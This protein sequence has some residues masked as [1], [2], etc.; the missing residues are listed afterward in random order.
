MPKN[1][2]SDLKLGV[3]IW[4][5][6]GCM[7]DGTSFLSIL[8]EFSSHGFL[9]VASGAPSGNGSSTVQMMRDSINWVSANAGK[10][11]YAN[12]DG[13]RIAV[14][15]QSCGGLEAYEMRNDTRVS[16]FGIFNSG[17]FSEA[18]SKSVASAMKVP[19][20]YFLGGSSDIA[21]ANVRPRYKKHYEIS[22]CLLHLDSNLSTNIMDLK[23]GRARLQTSTCWTSSLERKPPRRPYW[24]IY[25]DKRWEVR[26]SW[27]QV[28][29]VGSPRKPYLGSVF[30][31][32]RG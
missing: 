2:P 12:V 11:K 19:V 29:R 30:P 24:N 6:G 1:I 7:A 27:C 21:Y 4:G 31:W 32:F 20:F 28:S 23:I 5:E 26:S 14:A 15:G 9:V 17:E 3:L 22:P 18:D 13:T 25:S 8:T 16:A 10:G